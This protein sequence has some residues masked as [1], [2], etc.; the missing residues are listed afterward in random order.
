MGAHPWILD[1]RYAGRQLLTEVQFCVNTMLST[2]G[3]SADLMVI[4][5]NPADNLGCGD[6]DGDLLFAQDTSLS[7]QFVAQWE[8]RVMAQETPPR[9]IS[10]SKLRRILAFNK[11]FD[12]LGVRVGN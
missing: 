8:L 7:G 12:S 1:G 10:N 11:S 3:F 5:S 2:K 4:G 6:G 9:E